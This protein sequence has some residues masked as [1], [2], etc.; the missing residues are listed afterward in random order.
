MLLSLR[1]VIRCNLRQSFT[2]IHIQDVCEG[3]KGASSLIPLLVLLED[4]GI[5]NE[6]DYMKSTLIE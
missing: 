4:M 2:H 6:D 5:S 3:K 1:I